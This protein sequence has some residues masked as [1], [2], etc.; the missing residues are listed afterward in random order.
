VLRRR[1]DVLAAVLNGVDYDE[2]DPATDAFIDTP[3]DVGRVALKLA[4]KADLQRRSGLV[5]DPGAPVFGL[6]ARLVK[7]KGI[8]VVVASID[9]LVGLGAQV[10]VAGVGEERYHRALR[11]ASVR[12]S[13]MVA[14]HPSGDEATARRVYAGADFFLAP[15]EY[16]PCGLSPLIALRYGTIPI[17]RRTGGMADTIEDAGDAPATGLGFTFTTK[18]PKALLGGVDRALYAWANG[19]WG[20]LLHRAMRADFSWD[21]PADAY[22]ALY[23]QA[24]AARR[25]GAASAEVG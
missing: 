3:Y 8:D 20:A 21:G 2:F 25:M 10:V 19:S 15:S 12:H 17:V 22:L 7:Q 1:A 23:E 9:R 6:V 11:R 14:H 13:G 16:E 5:E 18:T 4:N 24:M